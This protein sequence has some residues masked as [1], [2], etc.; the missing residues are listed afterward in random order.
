VDG[1]GI[2]KTVNL[3]KRLDSAKMKSTVVILL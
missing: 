3:P 1:G 2:G